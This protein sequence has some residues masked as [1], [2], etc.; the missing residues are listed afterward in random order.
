MGFLAPRM[1]LAQVPPPPAP[2]SAPP[3]VP[4]ANPASAKNFL[5]AGEKAAKTKDWAIALSQYQASMAAQPSSQALEGIANAQYELKLPGDAYDSYDLLLKDYGNAIGTH[6]KKQAE[7]RLKEL[8]ALSGYVSIRVNETGADVSLD[9]RVIGQ[10]PVAALIRVS[11]GPHKV[12]VSKAG[13]TPVSKTPNVGANGKEIVDVQLAHE[14]TTGH[15]VIKEKSGQ[16]VRVL[17]DGSDVGAAP[18]DLEVSPGSHEVVLRSSTMA[19]PA[20]K[21]DV[22]KGESAQVELAAVAASAHLEVTTSDRKGIIFLDAKPVAEGAFTGDVAVGP[23][24]IAV[25]REGFERFE[26]RISLSDKQTLAETVTLKLPEAAAAGQL[27]EERSFDGLY[28]GLGVFGMIEPGGNGNEIETDCTRLGAASCKT[29]A[30]IG[31]GLSGWFG[32]AWHPVGVELYLAGSYDQTTPSATFLQASSAVENPLAVGVPRVE[33]F[34]FL[35]FGGLGA[36]RARVSFQT[37]RVRGSFAAGFGLAYKLMLF[38]RDSKA[39]VPGWENTYTD[40]SGHSYVSPAI[41]L[42]GSISL[43]VSPTAA[44]ALGLMLMFETAGSDLQSNPS[45]NQ[46]IGSSGPPVVG[47][48][49]ITTPA[50]HLAT[51]AQTFIGPYIGL[52]FGP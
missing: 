10:S 31:A 22:A 19:S 33:Q 16:A 30:P 28:G 18:I 51:G 35:R 23:H 44:V 11:A 48:A 50:Y 21:V 13:F 52:Q 29:P 12:D 3:P 39:N 4:A 20:Q 40:K 43:R 42:D 34:A 25:T 7:T 8:A 26:K 38:E 2:P 46:V 9:G 5:A 47:G 49:P 36:V 6:A 17:V 45:G 32:Y 24:T 1:V 15:L 27:E 37:A 41:S 14:A